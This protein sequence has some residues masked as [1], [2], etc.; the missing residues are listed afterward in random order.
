MFI[1]K[2]T[3]GTTNHVNNNLHNTAAAAAAALWPPVGQGQPTRSRS[4]ETRRNSGP[5]EGEIFQTRVF[6][7]CLIHQKQN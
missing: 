6:C 3:G 4:E 7:L 1:F 5:E 2:T